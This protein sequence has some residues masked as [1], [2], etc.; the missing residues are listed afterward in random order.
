MLKFFLLLIISTYSMALPYGV[1][2]PCDNRAY[3]APLANSPSVKI[4]I[5]D[6]EKKVSQSFPQWNQAAYDEFFSNGNRRGAEDML[7]A[8]KMFLFPLVIAECVRYDGKYLSK[9]SEAVISLLRQPSWVLPAHVGTVSN[10]TAKPH[11]FDIFTS[12][13][14]VELAQVAHLLSK[15]LPPEVIDEINTTI[16]KRVQSAIDDDLDNFVSQNWWFRANNNWIPVCGRGLYYIAMNYSK[17]QFSREKLLRLIDSKLEDYRNS[18]GPDG[19][20]D[21]GMDYWH[22]GLSH[23]AELEFFKSQV[24]KENNQEQKGWLNKNNVISFRKRFDMGGGVYSSIGDSVY[25]KVP[26][27]FV[28]Y[29]YIKNSGFSKDSVLPFSSAINVASLFRFPMM[30]FFE[31]KNSISVGDIGQYTYFDSGGVFIY[32][33]GGLNEISLAFKGGVSKSHAHN[34]SGSFSLARRGYISI[35]DIGRPVYTKSTFGKDRNRILAISSFGHSVPVIAGKYQ[36]SYPDVKS[37]P[38]SKSSENGNLI[39][40]KALLGELYGK[41]PDSF[42]REIR[43]D[44]SDREYITLVDHFSLRHDE[45]VEEAFV[46]REPVKIIAN[47]TIQFG[48]DASAVCMNASK[49]LGLNFY[50]QDFSS[51]GIKFTRVSTSL[52]IGSSVF[53]AKFYAGSCLGNHAS[54]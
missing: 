15:N 29:W 48:N 3:W 10:K 51:D 7:N 36:L 22:Y 14:V 13:L 28:D 32:R 30:A 1:G 6:A 4:A 39:S 49:P 50:L 16:Y 47:S 24:L 2:A 44:K 42:S 43:I 35:G 45:K 34:D 38:I 5:R 27:R 46:T 37:V 9:I 12:Q 18:F 54:D 41:T 11:I 21:E 33:A 40:V 19:Y 53:L 20:A 31:N 52:P 17:N 8:R 26:E 25:G 23:Y